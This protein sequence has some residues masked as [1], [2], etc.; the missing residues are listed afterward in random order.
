VGL[1]GVLQMNV[2]KQQQPEYSAPDD[3]TISRAGPPDEE[4]QTPLS[5]FREMVGELVEYRELLFQITLRDI[6]IRYKQSV[7]GLAWAMLMPMFIVGAG[8]L[9]KH[10]MAQATRTELEVDSFAGMTVKA[11]SWTF[12]AGCVGFATTS[13]TANMDMITKIYFPREVFP[14]S[15]TLVQVIDTLIA[16]VVL[17]ALL[18]LVLGGSFSIQILWTVPLV[19]LL[20][21]LSAGAGLFLSCA[22]LFFRDVK[23]IV[24][25]LLT[26]GVFF[27][28][29]FYE[30]SHL[31][32]HGSVLMM[33]N[34]LAPILE[35]LRLVI[36]EHH[37]LF[38]AL[39]VA[40]AAGKE[41]VA[42]HPAYLLYSTIWS[43]VG[44]LGA[45]VT[46]HKLEFVYAEYI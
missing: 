32:P 14:L 46:F 34:P 45:W 44:G 5:T 16:S 21:T 3:A 22:N 11:L 26:C 2:P 40:S 10:V 38:D 23:Y 1:W 17:A 25:V 36:V 7:M 24:Q 20:F 35:G 37:N 41:I 19:L 4:Y 15:A 30:A 33:F 8:L 29:V 42:W 39:V 9:I 28:P 43:L 12:F 13:L 31:G 18:L 6:R 27:T